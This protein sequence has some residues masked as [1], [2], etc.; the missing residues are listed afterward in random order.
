MRLYQPQH[1]LHGDHRIGGTAALPQH[2]RAGLD[3]QRI[4][5]GD[6]PILRLDRLA[7]FLRGE[8]CACGIREAGEEID[9]LYLSDARLWIDRVGG[10]LCL[11]RQCQKQ[12][13]SCGHQCETHN[14]LPVEFFS[15]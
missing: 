11:S 8:R 15:S 2:P 14:N 1:R 3:R 5:G 7:G 13:A 6:H 12:R 10:L 4:G 9:R